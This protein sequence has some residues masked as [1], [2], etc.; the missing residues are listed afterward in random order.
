[1]S[2]EKFIKVKLE[3]DDILDTKRKLCYGNFCLQK[4]GTRC[5]CMATKRY[6]Q[7][8]PHQRPLSLQWLVEKRSGPE[9]GCKEMD[10]EQ[11]RGMQSRITYKVFDNECC[12]K[13]FKL[14]FCVGNHMLG[15][16]RQKK[17][18]DIM[19]E[20]PLGRPKNVLYF[21][22]DQRLF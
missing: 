20:R 7:V 6:L 12:R 13:A 10:L 22:V 4:L 5:I 17:N 9:E 8:K 1:M 11:K 2:N 16:V 21:I 14:V 3:K 18:Q 19:V 15:R